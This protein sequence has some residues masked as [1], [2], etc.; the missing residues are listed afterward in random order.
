[1]SIAVAIR[2]SGKIVLAT[3]SVS[4][5]GSLQFDTDNH[6]TTKV[7]KLSLIHI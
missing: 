1:M 2:K 7:V 3:D 6:K 5:F 4:T